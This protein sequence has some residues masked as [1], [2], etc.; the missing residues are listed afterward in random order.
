MI[1]LIGSLVLFLL[2]VLI[3]IKTYSDLLEFLGVAIGFISGITFI[4]CLI[5]WGCAYINNSDSIYEYE[6]N[7]LYIDS[8]CKNNQ[9]TDE[10]RKKA[11]DIV[12]STNNKILRTKRWRDNFVVGIYYSKTVGN[13]E[14][15]DINKVPK[16]T[17]KYNVDLKQ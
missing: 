8:L 11:I 10:E 9:L 4:I 1:L 13:L 2:G 16:A 6:Q 3:A 14:L 17:K 5:V 12:M 7:K 15:L